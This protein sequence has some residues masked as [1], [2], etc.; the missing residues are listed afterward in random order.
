V[1]GDLGGV[2][3]QG[4]ARTQG[5]RDPVPPGLFTWSVRRA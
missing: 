2:G 1:D 4:L 5:E 3:G